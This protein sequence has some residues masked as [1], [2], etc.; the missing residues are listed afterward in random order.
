MGYLTYSDA[1]DISVQVFLVQAEPLQSQTADIVA[2]PPLHALRRSR[3]EYQRLLLERM[4]A[5]DGSYQEGFVIP[6]TGTSPARTKRA[7]NNLDMNNPLS[8]HDE[9]CGY[10][11]ANACHLVYFFLQNP[12]T[13]WF[14]S[15]ELRKE[16]LQDVERTCVVPSVY[17]PDISF[18][19]SGSLISDTFV[20]RVFRQNLQMSSSCTLLP[21]QI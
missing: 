19:S 21:I 3:Q 13:A 4:R 9:V 12:W 20:T 2:S 11:T 7:D 5:P 10:E 8:L 18:T 17:L 1:S 15:M 6:G 14:T 16:I